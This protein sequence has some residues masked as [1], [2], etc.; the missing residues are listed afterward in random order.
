[1]AGQ[2]FTRDETLH[3]FAQ[4]GDLL[5]I[6]LA[7]LGQSPVG[8]A[9]SRRLDEGRQE[10]HPAIVQLSHDSIGSCYRM[11]M[12]PTRCNERP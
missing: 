3:G 8:I 2:V 12:R 5:R 10:G 4:V 9:V 11:R 6:D 7:D 1:M